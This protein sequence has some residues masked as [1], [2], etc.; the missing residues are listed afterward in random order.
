MIN[1][2]AAISPQA[3]NHS[4]DTVNSFAQTLGKHVLLQPP[5]PSAGS[6]LEISRHRDRK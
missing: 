5:P 2:L 1:G 6:G 3:I 4:T